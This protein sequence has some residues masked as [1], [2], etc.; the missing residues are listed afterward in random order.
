MVSFS[1]VCVCGDGYESLTTVLG[2]YVSFTEKVQSVVID[3]MNI[4]PGYVYQGLVDSDSTM[5][6]RYDTN[7]IEIPGST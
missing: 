7:F 4:R 5:S 3:Q 1:C 2:L 6:D